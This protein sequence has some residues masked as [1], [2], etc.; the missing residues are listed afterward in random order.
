MGAR[1]RDENAATG[2]YVQGEGDPGTFLR[3]IPG[4][5]PASTAQAYT[6]LALLAI[7][8]TLFLLRR[9][10]RG[11]LGAGHLHIGGA[12]AVTVL[13]YVLAWTAILRT[14][15]SWVSAKLPKDAATAVAYF[16]P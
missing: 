1:N 6:A 10:F 5:S 16:V 3:A 7:L 8:V 4:G 13:L 11:G 9:G 15:L 12:D 2:E 14:G